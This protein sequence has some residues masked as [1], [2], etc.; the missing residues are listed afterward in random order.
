MDELRAE[1]RA[2]NREW[3]RRELAAAAEARCVSRVSYVSGTSVR[4]EN[5]W[6]EVVDVKMRAEELLEGSGIPQTVFCPTWVM[7]VLPNFI[8]PGRAVVIE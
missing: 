4:E 6:F 7:E 3:L 8:R 2:S 1:L 5:R